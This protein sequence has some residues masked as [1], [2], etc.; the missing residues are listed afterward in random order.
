MPCTASPTENAGLA[1]Q[2]KVNYSIYTSCFNRLFTAFKIYYL[3]LPHNS[4]GDLFCDYA[5]RNIWRSCT[6]RHWTWRSPSIQIL[7]DISAPAG[8]FAS[9]SLTITLL[10][11]LQ[12]DFSTEE[13][14]ELHWPRKVQLIDCGIDQDSPTSWSTSCFSEPALPCSESLCRKEGG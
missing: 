3:L 12:L 11:T 7:M 8:H 5:F 1:W 4:R 13:K 6:A 9:L 10:L 2:P 14:T